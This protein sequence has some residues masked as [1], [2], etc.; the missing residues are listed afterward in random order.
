MS[1]GHNASLNP[2]YEK[3]QKKPGASSGCP[4]L[5]INSGLAPSFRGF[6]SFVQVFFPPKRAPPGILWVGAAILGGMPPQL[7]PGFNKP[8][9]CTSYPGISIAHGTL[10]WSGGAAGTIAWSKPSKWDVRGSQE[11]SLTS[12]QILS[13]RKINCSSWQLGYLGAQ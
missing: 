8:P 3:T 13:L 4:L 12:L 9:I 5:T 11:L 6:L 10:P 1:L 2:G 7:S